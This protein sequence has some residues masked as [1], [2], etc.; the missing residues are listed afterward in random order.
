VADGVDV[1]LRLE[2]RGERLREERDG[3]V[4]NDAEAKTVRMPREAGRDRLLPAAESGCG[5]L[6][7][8]RNLHSRKGDG[9]R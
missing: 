2:E 9:E 8:G 1:R 5:N 3:F 6:L 4:E 7:A